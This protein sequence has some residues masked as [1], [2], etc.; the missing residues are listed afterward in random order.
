MSFKKNQKKESAAL[1]LYQLIR[2]KELHRTQAEDSG[3]SPQLSKLRHW[4]AQRLARTYADLTENSRYRLAVAFF[5]N[6]LYGDKDFSQRDHDVERVYPIM[7][8]TLPT[9]ALLSLA[10]ALE[11]KALSYELDAQLLGIL[12]QE[13]GAID[14]IT[15]DVY[16]NAY[17]EA[18]NYPQRKHQIELIGRLGADLDRIV[19][20]PYIYATLRLSKRPAHLAGFGEL[21]EFLE[22]GFVAFRRMRGAGYFMDTIIRRETEILDRIYTHHPHP[23]QLDISPNSS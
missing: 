23:F 9:N 18:D 10:M 7:K 1:L 16:A 2:N 8:R 5:L 22:Q 4:Q 19:A 6:E 17:R 13:L 15:E 21:Q 20:K 12:S 14:R 11:L 3:L